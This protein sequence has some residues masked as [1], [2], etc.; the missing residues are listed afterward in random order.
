MNIAGFCIK[1]KVTTVL[2]FVIITIFGV[3]FY[4]NLKLAM[5]PNMEFPAAYVMCTYIGANPQDV[6]ELVTR[7]LESSI[8][9]VT[10]VKEISST[11]SENVSV[12]MIT[13][14]DGTDVDQ[15]AIKLREKFDALSLPDGCDSPI[16]NNFNINDMMPLA[17]IALQGDDLNHLQ[18][19][20]D[21]FV[22][23]ALERIDGVASAQVNG[24]IESQITVKTNPSLLSGYGLSISTISNYL[25]GG[26]ILYPGGDIQNGSN[27]LTV[28]TDGK[29]QSVDDVA[30]TIL[31]LPQG[32]SVRLDEVADVYMESS[33]KDSAAKVGDKNCVVIMLNKQSGANEVEVM[34][35]VQ[36]NLETLKQEN[37]AVDYF[38]AY[39]ASDYIVNSASSALTNIVLG[40][41]L[42]AIVVFAFLRRF[43][44]T[45][46]ISLSMPFC[47]VSV[48]L[49]MNFFGLT[50]NMI[51]LGAI[52]IC[53]GMVVD[54]SI[55]VL[56]NIYRYAG[57]GYPRYESCVLGTKEVVLPIM[58]ST[59][60]TI[61]VF[62]PV[63]LSG[64]IA[65]MVFKDFALTVV[66]L[67]LISLGI[68]LTLVPLLC[69]FLL[70]E[71][72]VRLDKLLAA[73]KD[74]AW[75]RF[76]GKLAR[77][78]QR[79][80][81]FLLRRRLVAVIISVVMVAGCLAACINSDMVLMP[82]MDQGMVNISVD[83]PIG[84]ELEDSMEYSDRILSIVQE[85]T[86]EIDNLYAIEQEESS[87]IIV[88]LV[89][90]EERS[91]SSVEVADDL[92]D[93]LRDI[94][95]C[96]ITVSD[97]S[98]MGS[99]MGG[100]SEIDV[101]ITGDDY[102]TLAAIANDIAAQIRVMDDAQ[103][104]NT[105]VE[106][107]IPAV[108]VTVNRSA[109]A[110]YNLTVATIGGAVRAE[111]T[112]TTATVVTIDGNDLDVVVQGNGVNAASLDALRSTPIATPTGGSVPLS[113]VADVS[114]EL[115]PQSISRYNQSRQVEVTGTTVS[116]ST[117][118]ITEQIQTL[119]DNYE[120]PEGYR[121][122]I[123]GS[124][125][126]M[127]E[128]FRSLGLAL[129]VAVGLV[130]FILASQFESFLMPIIVMLILPMSLSG[131][132]FGL[133]A[134][135]EDISM[136]VLLGLIMLTGTV[137]NSSIVLVDYVN[138]R[139]AAGMEKME[140]ILT[141]CP[142]RVRPILM[143]TFTTVFAMI[144]MAMGIGGE[145]SELLIPLGIVMIFGMVVSVVVTLLFTPVFYSLLDSLA[146]RVGRPFR[147]RQVSK[148][149]RLLARIAEL[150]GTD[151][152]MTVRAGDSER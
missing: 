73:R 99:M 28:T 63:G 128:N 95:G 12:V 32:G 140:A 121:A 21:D 104:V 29:F 114:V 50:L 1:H 14:E 26:N 41:C 7:P 147:R 49:V 6:E 97:Y 18:N 35:K 92:R 118:E 110:Q 40:V 124:Y 37:P 10:G 75:R 11:S 119:L 101:K 142:L 44:A 9:T 103:E 145:G 148:T 115:S 69:Y 72:K 43:G 64:G 77:G 66:F 39:D 106:N 122:E 129:L 130:Y 34:R 93:R 89:S 85:N 81:H 126:D 36:K 141:A 86:P 146:D 111:L 125:A 83:L 68:A 102:D 51:S 67:I 31:F 149:E 24:G 65:G 5:L 22:V 117:T 123:G 59:L 80:L 133:P 116:G 135:G 15:A 132:L 71:S 98:M 136:V 60:T 100:D 57:D 90:M 76:T 144:P 139:R 55:V 19:T 109:A 84:S 58:A 127:M 108:K 54:N 38:L 82:D 113:S 48:M 53:V 152:V 105:S 131:A 134:T 42:S 91:R 120:F 150:E 17:I 13:Y 46:T 27:T 25:A 94:A 112:G 137:V 47:V 23:P 45:L 2:A 107:T 56:E 16:I 61:A 52:A 87:T 74:S 8:A 96:D 79:I 20:A 3:V 143:T 151:P 30:N 70:E 33:L 78:Y 88:N 62:L 138:V 4:T